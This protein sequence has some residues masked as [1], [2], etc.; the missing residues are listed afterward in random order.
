MLETLLTNPGIIALTLVLAYVLLITLIVFTG[1]FTLAY[2]M[3]FLRHLTEYL[4][5]PPR[6]VEEASAKLPGAQATIRFAKTS[7]NINDVQSSL[8]T[9][10]EEQAKNRTRTDEIDR[11]LDRIEHRLNRIDQLLFE[12]DDSND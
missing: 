2:G 9:L 10:T 5:T 12:P 11:H 8:A 6:P 1:S 4:K 3:R 7:D